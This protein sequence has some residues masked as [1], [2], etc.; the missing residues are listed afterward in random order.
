MNTTETND[1]EIVEMMQK[2][3]MITLYTISAKV[4]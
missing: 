1:T 4:R 2:G 3:P